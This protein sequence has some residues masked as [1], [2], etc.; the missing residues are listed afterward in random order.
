MKQVIVN[1]L[2]GG[3]VVQVADGGEVNEGIVFNNVEDVISEV[4][5]AVKPRSISAPAVSTQQ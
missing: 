3:F 5:E 2:K 1:V 4:R